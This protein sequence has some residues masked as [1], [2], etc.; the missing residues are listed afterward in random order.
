MLEQHL[1]LALADAVAGRGE[2]H[3]GA[4]A[5]EAERDLVGAGGARD[6]TGTATET[7]GRCVGGHEASAALARHETLGVGSFHEPV[8]ERWYGRRRKLGAG[9]GEGR[10]R[11]ER[12]QS[13]LPSMLIGQSCTDMYDLNAEILADFSCMARE[14]NFTYSQIM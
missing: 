11:Q 14:G 4:G 3:L 10:L 12:S 2:H 13:I 9:L 6:V 7:Q 5:V 1:T 8:V